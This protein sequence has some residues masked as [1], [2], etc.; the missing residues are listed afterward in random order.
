MGQTFTRDRG[1]AQ[2]DLRDAL[3]ALEA[4]QAEARA[5]TLALAKSLALETLWPGIWAAPGQARSV[6]VQRA[7][8]LAFLVT[9]PDGTRKRFPRSQVPAILRDP[10]AEA[11]AMAAARFTG[12]TEPLDLT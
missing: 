1:N 6:W 10:V 4:K 2:G 9:A 3:E 11:A 5:L 7:D 8:S 12:Q